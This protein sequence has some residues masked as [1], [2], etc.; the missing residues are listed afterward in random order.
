MGQP[1]NA[2]AQL[3]VSLARLP[4]HATTR[5]LRQA[6]VLQLQRRQGNAYAQRLDDAM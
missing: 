6:A 2:L 4:E 3:D 1:I 5:P